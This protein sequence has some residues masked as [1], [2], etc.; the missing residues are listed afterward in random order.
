MP[1]QIVL[2]GVKL[3]ELERAYDKVLH[4]FFAYPA[5]EFTLSE[6]CEQLKISKTTANTV[7]LE[8]EKLKFLEHEVLGN[9]WRIY[10]NQKHPF[11]ITLRIPFNLKS[12]YQSDILE[13]VVSNVP[14][15]RAVILFGSYRKGDD[16]EKSDVDIAVEVV[17]NKEL[18]IVKLQASR[19]GYRENVHVNVHLFSRKKIDLNV[20]ASIANGIVLQ[21]FLEVRP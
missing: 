14:N 21:G 5:K 1:K 17:G 8:L 20:F 10:A 2:K 6:L 9:L 3:S 13:W 11:F 18:E 7:V 16:T 4:W 19:M 15:A 12:V